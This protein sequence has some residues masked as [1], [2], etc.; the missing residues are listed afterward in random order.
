VL[1]VSYV[2]SAFRA[3]DSFTNCIFRVFEV[4]E[5]VG[6]RD[7]IVGFPGASKIYIQLLK[8]RC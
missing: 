5:F 8:F 1:I 7:K 3:F 4:V 2:A 6:E